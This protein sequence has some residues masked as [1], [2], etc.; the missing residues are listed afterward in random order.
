M[1]FLDKVCL[2]VASPARLRSSSVGTYL[3]LLA[4]V[5]GVILVGEATI[6]LKNHFTSRELELGF[7]ISTPKPKIWGFYLQFLDL[8]CLVR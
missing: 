2:T 7:L 1:L 4:G 8:F 6:S 5:D 3:T